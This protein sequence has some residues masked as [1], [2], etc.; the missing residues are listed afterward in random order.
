MVVR[1][2]PGAPE[3]YEQPLMTVSPMEFD[4]YLSSLESQIEEKIDQIPSQDFY[5]ENSY[6]L[7]I[8]FRDNDPWTLDRQIY[9]DLLDKIDD[10]ETKQDLF[11][12]SRDIVETGDSLMPFPL[13]I[14]EETASRAVERKRATVLQDLFE[15]AKQEIH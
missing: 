13:S 9:R 10:V 2:V 15:E 14:V 8:E 12:Y 4:E 7:G 1:E 6:N 3:T 5:W 11:S